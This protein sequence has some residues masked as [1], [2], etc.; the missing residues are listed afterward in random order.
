MKSLIVGFSK[1]KKPFPLGSWTIRLYQGGTKYSHIYI[2]LPVK[3]NKFPSDK[4]LH[5]S[6]GKVQN[7]S[8]TQFDKRHEV[9]Q[10]FTIKVKKSLY[11]Q[12]VKEMH[13]AS[14]DDYSIMQNVGIVLVDI[15]R[16]FGVRIKNPFTSGW[17][18]SEFVAVILQT[19]MPQEFENISPDTV[20]PQ[21][22]YNI[23]DR[24]FS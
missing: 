13:E 21:D 19:I 8:G 18:C 22:I 12:V 24:L 10:E 16:L 1:S 9:V 14:G 5:A 17:N 3:G 7:M 23:L 20:T 2:R 15:C 4:I 6:E 11:N